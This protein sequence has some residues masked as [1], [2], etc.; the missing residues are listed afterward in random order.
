MKNISFREQVL[1]H[2]ISVGIFLVL[3]VIFFQPAILENKAL[4]QH[5][6]FQGRAAGYELKQYREADE[7]PLWINSMFSGMPAYLISV[8]YKDEVLKIFSKILSFGLPNPASYVFICF[9]S[10]YIMLLCF[11]VRP[12]LALG[13]AIIFGLTTFN[14]IS[15]SAGHNSKIHAVGYMPLVIAGI[16]TAFNKKLLLGFTITVIGLA[17]ELK[18]NHLQ[19]TYY[20][21]LITLIYGLVELIFHVKDKQL[22]SFGRAL[23]ILMIAAFV[24][25][26]ANL[27][28][29]WTVYEYGQHTIRGK[30]E[31]PVEDK[32]ANDS[33]LDKE[34]AFRYSN[35]IY[36]P[37]VM[38]IPNILGGK[39]QQSL[40]SDSN[41]GKAFLAQGYTRAQV[42]QQ[43][44]SVPTY[45]GEQPLTAPYYAGAITLLL[46][47]VGI[48]YADKRYVYWLVGASVLGIILSWGKN[49]EAFNYFMFDYF[50]GYNK[51]RS[52]TFAIVIP[53]F[54]MPLL[55][56]LGL[57]RLIT[58][59]LPGKPDKKFWMALGIPLG[60][61]GLIFII[62]GMF[63]Y[64]GAID[65]RLGNLPNWFIDALKDDR[66]SLLR[67]DAFRTLMFMALAA[68]ALW[69]CLRKKLSPML[70]GVILI[71][72]IGIDMISVG[73]RFLKVSDFTRDPYGQ[74]TRPTEADTYIK[75][76]NQEK[77]RVLYLLNPFNEART[78]IHHAS[79][80]GYHGAKLGRYQ[81][82][83]SYG[84]ESE[85]QEAITSLQSGSRDFS[86]LNVLNMLNTRYLI[87]GN[88]RGAVI[89]NPSA[90]GHAWFIEGIVSV[91]S[92][93]EEMDALIQL[94]TKTQAVVDVTKFSAPKGFAK[95]TISLIN[96]TANT[97]SFES[98]ASGAAFAVF[99]DIFY[100]KG[101]KAFVNGQETE[102]VR[103][104]YV[105]RALDLPAGKSEI[106]FR[107]EP[108]SYSVGTLI[109]RIVGYVLLILLVATI[110]IPFLPQ[111]N[112]E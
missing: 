47:F 50:P 84:M 83:I 108:G 74:F 57:D 48:F 82:L 39:S 63:S 104:N 17:L 43:L 75:Q 100:E 10:Y 67:T 93:K 23:G 34:Y 13:G 85:I 106:E 3:T 94:D 41:L 56:F 90:N 79:V 98:E 42:S 45:W 72:L 12:Y 6:V 60:I 51:F 49:F 64:S 33:G 77:A 99:S 59:G 71:T 95:G 38:F 105:L 81:D 14:L 87:A 46:F 89:K 65:S 52:V 97:V 40:D 102:I 27:G 55:G 22:K 91:N 112:A 21:L 109:N 58:D 70:F 29:I 66:Q 26:I 68:G 86:G 96:K 9:I 35:G 111:K 16:R 103:A 44:G 73:K 53:V 32:N 101:W 76:D 61:V 78:S 62:A 80:G 8:N 69:F 54:C 31:I 24:A 19:M 11:G 4:N 18:A 37:L 30:S 92:P 20:L 25:L 1:P 15:L 107:F 7:N 2:V 28:R 88:E 36:E 5:D 110:V